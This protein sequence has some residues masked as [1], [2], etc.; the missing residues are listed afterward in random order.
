ML[1]FIR[2]FNDLALSCK[3]HWANGFHPFE[4]LSH[5]EAVYL[6]AVSGCSDMQQMFK[7]YHDLAGDAPFS[8]FLADDDF[9]R[10]G[11]EASKV[12]V[13]PIVFA[14][15]PSA[16]EAYPGFDYALMTDDDIRILLADL[17]EA[18]QQG[19]EAVSS[20]IGDHRQAMARTGA[21]MAPSSTDMAAAPVRSL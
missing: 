18:W 5:K 7:L 4:S 6:W 12:T 1:R 3:N 16:M 21:R 15:P 11:R 20:V 8:S 2:C 17:G 14:N 10:S 9:A 13:G 19:W